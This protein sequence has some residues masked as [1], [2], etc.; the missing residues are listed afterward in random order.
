MSAELLAGLA[1]GLLSLLMSYIPGL[2]SWYAA[3]DSVKK[4]LIMLG[5]LVVVAAAVYGLSCAGWAAGWGFEQTCDQAG[6]Q[7]LIAA[8]VAALVMNQATYKISPETN[9]VQVAKAAR[10]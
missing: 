10:G 5:A 8:F 1:G 3:L 2:N 4:S 9:R 7:K 6:L